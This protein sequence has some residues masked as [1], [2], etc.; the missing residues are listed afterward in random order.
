MPNVAR[1]GKGASRKIGNAIDDLFDKAKARLLGPQAIIGKKIH[2]GFI[3]ELSLP[4]VFEAGS[5]EELVKPDLDVLDSLIRVAGSY[6]DAHRERTKARV[7]HQINGAMAEAKHN[8]GMSQSD[9]RGLVNTQ[10]SEVWADVTRNIHSIVDTELSHAKNV[11]VLD[12]VVGANLNAGVSDPVVYFVVVRDNILCKECKRLH[13]MDDEKTPRLWYLSELGHGYHKKGEDSPKIGGLH[14]HC[15][16]TLVTLLPSYGFT[17]D[18]MVKYVKRGHLELPIQ[19]GLARSEPE[20]EEPLEKGWK[21]VVAGAA[22]ALAPSALDNAPF[23]APGPSQN[24]QMDVVEPLSEHLKAV[25]ILESSGG[26]NVNHARGKDDYDTAVGAVGLKPKTA[27]IEWMR[28]KALQ[29]K[30]QNLKDPAAFTAAFKTTPGLYNAAANRHWGHLL[31]FFKGDVKRALYGWRFG[32]FAAMRAKPAVYNA[33]GYTNAGADLI[34]PRK[35]VFYGDIFDALMKAALPTITQSDF[36][37][38]MQE[39]GWMHAGDS[40]HKTKHEHL[41]GPSW[42]GFQHGEADILDR[43]KQEKYLGQIGMTRFQHRGEWHFAIDPRLATTATGEG[44]R[45]M[46]ARHLLHA[47]QSTGYLDTHTMD[48]VRNRVDEEHKKKGSAMPGDADIEKAK[49]RALAAQAKIASRTP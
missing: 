7:V 40:K 48:A 23:K 9:F 21:G 19:R 2:I 38:E 24:V 34:G 13:L 36:S 30:Y 22:L 8:G 10:L 45:A 11:S 49:A 44:E 25:S 14:P 6:I 16:C 47:Y 35:S 29:A 12:G 37:K 39:F 26:K 27:H 18:G 1:L 46:R 32:K 43:N 4:G 28:D 31:K 17:N 42:A 5:L 41:G 20:L 15:R 3:R 33:H